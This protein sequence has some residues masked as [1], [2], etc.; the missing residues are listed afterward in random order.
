[1]FL[2]ATLAYMFSLIILTG[3]YMIPAGDITY[4]V[5]GHLGICVVFL[6]KIHKYICFSF[7]NHF[8]WFNPCVSQT[9][10]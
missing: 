1:M 9:F 7:Q 8:K 2:L 3:A 10:M 4:E 5:R 6:K